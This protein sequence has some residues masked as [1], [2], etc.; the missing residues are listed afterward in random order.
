VHASTLVALN[1]RTGSLYEHLSE[2]LRSKPT[3]R[4]D[5][6]TSTASRT[7]YPTLLQSGG[8][9]TGFGRCAGKAGLRGCSSGLLLLLRCELFL[10]SS[11]NQGI[12]ESAAVVSA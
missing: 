3:R 8:L 2:W 7:G 11:E 10:L 1:S 9:G 6:S 5:G 12:D 4:R